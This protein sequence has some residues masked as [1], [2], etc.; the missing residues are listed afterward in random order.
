MM[1][2]RQASSSDRSLFFNRGAVFFV[3]FLLLFFVC[4][5]PSVIVQAAED[6][7]SPG[8]ND[9]P[10]AVP[11]KNPDWF[12]L[13]FLDL[14]DDLQEAKDAGKVG[15]ILYFG[16]DRC[17]YCKALLD[18]NFSK[19]DITRYTQE[20]FDVIALDVRGSR[21]VTNL[22]G[23]QISEKEFSID[24]N[25][26]FTPTLLF[27]DLTGKEVHRMVGYYQPY[28][29]MAALEYVADKH[30]QKQPFRDYLSR[31][32]SPSRDGKQGMN[33]RAF[34]LPPPHILDRSRFAGQRPLVV[35][36]E[37]NECHACDILHNGPLTNA[38]I[39]AH[40]SEFDM[41]QLNAWSKEPIITP[42][43]KRM[44]AG[45]WAEKL[46]IFYTP[47]VLFFDEQGNEIV[48]IASVVHFNRL[49]RVLQ[50]VSS[51]GYLK[52]RNFAEWNAERQSRAGTK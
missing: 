16:Q 29:F 47:T 15:I 14:R 11:L 19:T 51:K 1:Y 46:D 20:H 25:A 21:T 17:P 4:L 31:A 12:K 3:P 50:Y 36:F 49:S 40:I 37:Q 27:Y 48:R 42:K 5:C 26:N 22:E 38:E 34:F 7:L 9:E 32:E 39:L 6:I 13:S 45:Q 10:I 33:Q 43:G 44:T 18:V 23:R 52:Y 35:F 8:F 41:V 30:Y 2:V 24:E 28:T